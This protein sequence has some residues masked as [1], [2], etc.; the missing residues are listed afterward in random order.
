MSWTALSICLGVTN[1]LIFMA[2]MTIQKRNS[3]KGFLFLFGVVNTLLVGAILPLTMTLN[4][5]ELLPF[6]P[7]AI[8]YLSVYMLVLIAF[9]WLWGVDLVMNIFKTRTEEK[10]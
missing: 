8:G 1:A 6:Q 3:L 10:E 4:V 2:V 9:I 7:L 5:V